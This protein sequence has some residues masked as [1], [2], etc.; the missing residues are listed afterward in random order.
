MTDIIERAEA[1]LEVA[2]S[3]EGMGMVF[4]STVE[5]L[6]AALKAARAES[7]GLRLV[8]ALLS[9]PG[10]VI[11]DTTRIDPIAEAIARNWPDTYAKRWPWA[12]IPEADR[13]AYRGL[14][15]TALQAAQE[16]E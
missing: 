5:G 2:H 13:E 14:A 15:R 8:E 9:S 4:A 1:A 12:D 6:V 3:G 7:Q 10:N 16:Q 11:I